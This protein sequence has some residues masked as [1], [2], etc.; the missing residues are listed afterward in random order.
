MFDWSVDWFDWLLEC[1]INWLVE[2]L[3]AWLIDW[4]IGWLADWPTDW[5]DLLYFGAMRL[6]RIGLIAW[7]IGRLIDW[8]IDSVWLTDRL[9][10]DMDCSIGLC[11]YCFLIDG[12][13]R[14]WLM[15]AWF[16]TWLIERNASIDR[17]VDWSLGSPLDWW[18]SSIDDSL[19]D[20]LVGWLINWFGWLIDWLIGWSVWLIGCSV[21]G[22]L[23]QLIDLVDVLCVCLLAR[24][25]D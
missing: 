22:V 18:T 1:L 3:I 7:L 19:I 12:W 15:I 5:F 10:Y 2:G 25:V 20:C 13:W 16:S 11:F 9:P 6:Y 17:M 8:L 23:A 21:H 14:D 4:L 24:V